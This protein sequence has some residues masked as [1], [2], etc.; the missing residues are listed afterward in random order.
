MLKLQ[1]CSIDRKSVVNYPQ[2]VAQMETQFQERYTNGMT[3]VV[4]SNSSNKA[5]ALW[6]SGGNPFW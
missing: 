2:D 4:P 5:V 3:M 1:K 6:R